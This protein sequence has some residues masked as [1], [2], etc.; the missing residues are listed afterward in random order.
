[1]EDVHGSDYDAVLVSTDHDAIDYARL[2]ELTIP[3]VDT[4]NAIASRGLPTQL[5]TKA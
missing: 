1:M 2:V 5:V 4:R 3:I